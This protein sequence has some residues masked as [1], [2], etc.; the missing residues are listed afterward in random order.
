MLSIVRVS[1]FSNYINAS[2]L[3]CGF[4]C[5]V[6]VGTCREN[7]VRNFFLLAQ[8]TILRRPRLFL[9][10]TLGTTHNSQKEPGLP[11]SLSRSGPADRYIGGAAP[12]AFARQNHLCRIHGYSCTSKNVLGFCAQTAHGGE[13]PIEPHVSSPLRVGLET[14][15]MNRRY[16]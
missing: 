8:Q 16:Q 6:S 13:K 5:F 10:L 7:L 12:A 14:R 15:C 9:G 3:V 11:K 4:V 2:N 1:A